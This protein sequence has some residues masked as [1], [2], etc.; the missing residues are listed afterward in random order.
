MH[1]TST[2]LNDQH[3][4]A[5]LLKRVAQGDQKAFAVIFEKHWK[6]LYQSVYRAVENKEVAQDIVQ[7]C[8]ISLWE[9]SATTTIDNVG[10]YLYQAVK[11]RYFMH[12]RSGYISRKHL[13]HLNTVAMV[14][15]T[16][17]A[18]AA[19]ELQT[20]LDATLASLPE[21]CREIFYL[22]RFE[23]LPNKKI[24]EQLHISPKTVEN[25]IT[26]A[27]R[28]LRVSVDKLASL[29]LVMLSGFEQPF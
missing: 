11:Y 29:A 16:E 10:G 28:I 15:S 19:Q 9:K 21:K 4:D 18:M 3:A 25:Q 8:F 24:A 14:N 20:V 13:D 2:P 7:D 6:T 5:E 17:E 27:L 26:K 23:S 22:S 1:K 12:L